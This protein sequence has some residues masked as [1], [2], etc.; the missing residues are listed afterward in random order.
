MKTLNQTAHL[1]VF[2]SIMLIACEK[3]THEF[4]DT[5]IIEAYLVAGQAPAVHISRQIPFVDYAEYA[6]DQIDSLQVILSSDNEIVTL[7]SNGEGWYADSSMV[8]TDSGNYEL[9][10]SFNS[11]NVLAQ[12]YIPVK[13]L[14]FKQSV[15][16]INVQRM[17]STSGPPSV[18]ADPVTLSWTNADESTYLIVI[19]NMEVK[20]DP[21]RRLSTDDSIPSNFFR[22]QPTESSEAEIRP[23]DFQY[24][25]THR[26]I[27]YHVLADYANL[28]SSS[29]SSSQNLTNPASAIINGYGIFT[30]MSADT[31]YI[32]VIEID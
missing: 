3:Q 22:Q 15:T 18:M 24:F 10:F 8:V 19:E 31:L 32:R 21:I 14:N 5:P 29:T 1:L 20:P 17:D 12:T 28:Y 23:M 11:K 26:I 9:Q 27:L 30:G 6:D 25:G 7:T 2:A 13:P 4:T 16:K